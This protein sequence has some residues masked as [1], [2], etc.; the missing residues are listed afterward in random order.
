MSH[1]YC[2]KIPQNNLQPTTDGS[3]LTYTHTYTVYP[4]LFSFLFNAKYY[5]CNVERT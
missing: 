3:E 2:D 1:C 4:F 5:M